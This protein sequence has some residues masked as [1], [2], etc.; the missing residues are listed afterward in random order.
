M[1]ILNL[2]F[3]SRLSTPGNMALAVPARE[4]IGPFTKS[5]RSAA[6]N[7]HEEIEPTPD[8]ERPATTV[9]DGA[10]YLHAGMGRGLVSRR[11]QALLPQE[12]IRR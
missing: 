4:H 7:E 1:A 9:P 6:G 12:D 2:D 5:N 11:R 3:R 10:D 8:L